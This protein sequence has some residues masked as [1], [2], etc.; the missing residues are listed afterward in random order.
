MASA[1][2]TYSSNATLTIDGVAE[3]IIRLRRILFSASVDGSLQ[4]VTDSGGAA[5]PISPS[6][7]V[8]QAGAS[9]IDLLFDAEPLNGAR[10]KNVAVSAT[11]TGDYS[12]LVE[13][14]LVD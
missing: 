8:R 10:G 3:K 2:G 5:T 14:E 7:Y 6:L 1:Y 12:V 9:T 11:V 4:V 13:Y